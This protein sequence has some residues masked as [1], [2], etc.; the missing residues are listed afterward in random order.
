MVTKTQWLDA[1]TFHL[2]W[3]HLSW[4]PK[5][6]TN[7]NIISVFTE[8]TTPL[9][10]LSPRSFGSESNGRFM[11]VWYDRMKERDSLKAKETLYESMTLPPRCTFH[12]SILTI[13]IIWVHECWST[14]VSY[15]KDYRLCT[16]ASRKSPGRATP[17]RSSCGWAGSGRTPSGARWVTRR[18]KEN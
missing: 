11:L 12:I 14:F 9:I 15:S 6:S 10:K 8:F 17:S 4:T 7:T 18:L 2:I 1:N 5:R 16:W 3:P 13:H